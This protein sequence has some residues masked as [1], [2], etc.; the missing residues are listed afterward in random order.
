MRPGT[1]AS[2]AAPREKCTPCTSEEAQLPTP[3]MATRIF[4][5][6]TVAKTS[7]RPGAVHERLEIPDAMGRRVFAQDAF[8]G[9]LAEHST[10]LRRQVGDG[11]FDVFAR[12]RQ[13]DFATRFEK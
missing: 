7:I 2:A 11:A 1:K 8:A 4:L 5:F 13:E 3:M 12:S 6:I 10:P 9:G